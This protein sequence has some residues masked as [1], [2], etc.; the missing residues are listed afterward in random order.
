MVSWN[1]L[2]VSSHTTA[3]GPAS[4]GALRNLGQESPWDVVVTNHKTPNKAASQLPCREVA[5]M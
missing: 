5:A 3:M 2:L 4:Q 1:Q